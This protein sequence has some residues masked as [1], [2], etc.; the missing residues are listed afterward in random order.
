[1]GYRGKRLQTF[2]RG[3]HAISLGAK[4]GGEDYEKLMTHGG[5]MGGALSGIATTME[6][7]GMAMNGAMMAL[8]PEIEILAAIMEALVDALDKVAKQNQ[9]IETGAGKGGIFNTGQGAGAFGAARSALNPRTLGSLGF[10]Q[11][12][13]SFERNVAIAGAMAQGGF[14]LNEL[15][16]GGP[17]TAN[18]APGG[19]GAKG[20]FMQGPIGEVQRVVMGVGR[21]AGLTD[22][23]GVERVLKNLTQYG[24]TIQ[25]TEKFFVQ[26]NKDTQAAGVS[27]TKYLSIIDEVSEHFDQFNKSLNETMGLL[28][29]LGRTGAI[30]GETL[31]DL[32]DFLAGSAKPNMQNAAQRGFIE[33]NMSKGM[34]DARTGGYTNQILGEIGQNVLPQLMSTLPANL[35]PQNLGD[36]ASMNPRDAQAMIQGL[37]DRLGHAVD[38]KGNPINPTTAAQ[39]TSALNTLSSLL[40]QLDASKRGSGLDR[41]FLQG[42]TGQDLL[43]S[44]TQ[45][46]TAVKISADKAGVPMSA[47]MGGDFSGLSGKQAAMMQSL[48]TEV[49]GIQDPAQAANRMRSLGTV[50]GESRLDQAYGDK[51]SAKELVKQLVRKGLFKDILHD[52]MTGDQSLQALKSIREG[53]DPVM[54]GK[55]V[56]ET[57]ALAESQEWFVKNSS[58]VPR[59]M[60]QQRKDALEEARELASQTQPVTEAIKNAMNVWMTKLIGGIDFI[61]SH[62]IWGGGQQDLAE[63]NK[64]YAAAKG[65]FDSVNATLE[66]EMGENRK[67]AKTATGDAK[68]QLDDQYDSLNAMQSDIANFKQSG[69]STP[70][71]AKR[72]TEISNNAS[73]FANHLKYGTTAAGLGPAAVGAHYGPL[74]SDPTDFYNSSNVTS[75]QLDP[76]LANL[77]S[78]MGAFGKGGDSHF[79]L[80]QGIANN[81][82][83]PAQSQA[84]SNETPHANAHRPCWLAAAAFGEDFDSGVNTNTVRN[85]LQKDWSKHWYA[86]PVLWLYGKYG[87]WAAQQ[88]LLV[89]I[90]RPLMFKAL[91]KAKAQ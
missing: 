54:Q 21:L 89:S 30:G 75:R 19:G 32:A 40:Q 46:L 45:R 39:S 51:S 84:D 86:K 55:L 64:A 24:Q 8:G 23:E 57:A 25:A 73:D 31:K 79:S 76:A 62:W 66:S 63:T 38:A 74:A 17:E 59:V 6:N 47:L 88:P 82:F 49:T 42:L 9:A 78:G 16:Q 50:M 27:T 34:R 4:T 48:M 67:Q 12:G 77:I 68:R 65:N 3:E 44:M 70:D 83:S 10:S 5:G 28:R 1:M 87:K 36:I 33:M 80:Y 91:A 52:N 22:V 29:N 11:L 26:L 56:T 7:V 2:V 61:V 85:W 13:I 71:D 58:K 14:N 72:W 15:T 60:E 43:G 41:S 20:Q 18:M 69:F 37:K 53:T 35:I 90:F 81:P